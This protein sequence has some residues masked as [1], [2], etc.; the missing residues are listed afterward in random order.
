MYNP[1]YPGEILK[2]LY[3]KPLG[4]KQKDLAKGLKVTKKA[5]SEL[6]NGHT[7]MSI[8]MAVKLSE[9]FDTTPEF[10]LNLQMKYDLFTVKERIDVSYIPHYRESNRELHA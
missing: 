6:M 8:E 5:L 3:M 4:I 9:A 1:P 7:S 10:W 2:G